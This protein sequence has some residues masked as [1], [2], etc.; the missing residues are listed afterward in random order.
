MLKKIII[1]LITLNLLGCN[2][3]ENISDTS[4]QNFK[5][6]NVSYSATYLT[7]NYSIIKG[8]AYTASEILDNNLK[9]IKLFHFFLI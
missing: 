4:Y 6:D 5:K 7:A 9:N 3:V 1:F 8:D 2:L